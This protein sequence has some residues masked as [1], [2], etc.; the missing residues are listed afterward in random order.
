MN[1]HCTRGRS[2]PSYPRSSIYANDD[3][4]ATSLSPLRAFTRIY[5]RDRKEFFLFSFIYLF[6]FFFSIVSKDY[7]RLY[8]KRQSKKSCD[9]SRLPL[10]LADGNAVSALSDVTFV[11]ERTIISINRNPLAPSSLP[12]SS[13]TL[14]NSL[15]NHRSVLRFDYSP[16]FAPSF[17]RKRNSLAYLLTY[18]H[19]GGI[20]K[21]AAC[22]LPTTPARLLLL[23]PLLLPSR[24]ERARLNNSFFFF[25]PLTPL[26]DSR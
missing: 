9:N 17:A 13:R 4:P 25:F 8:T 11:G 20:D 22:R 12:Y 26:R 19:L 14:S 18:Y 6:I 10:I 21:V 5:T 1:K 24:V 16:R 2:I 23:L 3:A 7:R 15:T